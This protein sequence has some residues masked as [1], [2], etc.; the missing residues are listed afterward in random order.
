M[1]TILQSHLLLI[2]TLLIS[3]FPLHAGPLNVNK[4]VATIESL[5]S[6]PDTCHRNSVTNKTLNEIRFWNWT[7]EDWTDNVYIHEL[8]NYIDKVYNGEESNENLETYRSILKSKFVI[9]NIEPSIIGGIFTKIVFLEEPSRV[10]AGHIY[11]TVDEDA[12][13]VTS[14]EVRSLL[15]TDETSNFTKEQILNLI[16]EHPEIKLF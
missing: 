5:N 14:Y 16:A 2:I 12:E 8:R 6:I 7:Y 15:P 13:L 10:F 4:T 11:S 9:Y 3:I 1:K